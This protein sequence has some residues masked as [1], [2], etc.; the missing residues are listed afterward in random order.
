[1]PETNRTNEV[2]V[3]FAG[4]LTGGRLIMPTVIAAGLAAAAAVTFA[5]ITLRLHQSQPAQPGKLGPGDPGWAR[6]QSCERVR[7]QG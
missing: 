3:D 1:M 5:V 7:G 4:T 6:A 2:I